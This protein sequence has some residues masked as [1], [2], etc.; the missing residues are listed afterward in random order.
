MR[1]GGPGFPGQF[2]VL[3]SGGVG[4]LAIPGTSHTRRT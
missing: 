4:L 3:L 1:A 2:R